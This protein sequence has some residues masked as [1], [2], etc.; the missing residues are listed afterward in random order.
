M[1]EIGTHGRKLQNWLHRNIFEKIKYIGLSQEDVPYVNSVS[2]II[3]LLSVGTG[4][5]FQNCHYVKDI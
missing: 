1:H 4:Q 3:R 2:E 5:G